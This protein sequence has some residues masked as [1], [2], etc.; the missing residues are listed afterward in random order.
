MDHE[1]LVRLAKSGKN[2]YH[3]NQPLGVFRWIGDN[4]SLNYSDPNRT[5]ET[6]WIRRMYGVSFSHTLNGTKL[7]FNIFR[8][9]RFLIRVGENALLKELKIKKKFQDQNLVWF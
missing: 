3:I 8:G 7:F 4:K 2:F 6:L 9:L 1:F 5:N